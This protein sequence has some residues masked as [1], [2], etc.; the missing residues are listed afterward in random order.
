MKT[1]QVSVKITCSVLFT[2]LCLTGMTAGCVPLLSKTTL[3]PQKRED[4]E[5]TD[6][7]PQSMFT[8]ATWKEYSQE[9]QESFSTCFCHCDSTRDF[10][11]RHSDQTTTIKTPTHPCATSLCPPVR[12][13]LCWQ[14]RKIRVLLSGGQ[15]A[16][17]IS[18]KF[19]EVRKTQTN[20][21]LGKK[22]CLDLTLWE[23][24]QRNQAL[25]LKTNSH[26]ICRVSET[27]VQTYWGFLRKA[28]DGAHTLQLGHPLTMWLLDIYLGVR[29]SPALS[30][31]TQ[32]VFKNPF[33]ERWEEFMEL[34]SWRREDP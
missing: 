12:H 20:A 8:A 17:V 10:L 3:M 28:R 2:D 7:V 22:I 23:E 32:A 9:E 34:G 24:P 5:K 11:R 21:L 27:K 4:F 18:A 26:M 15:T 19:E 1:K 13:R 25:L 14:I 30:L 31:R 29:G 16:C 33:P 6:P